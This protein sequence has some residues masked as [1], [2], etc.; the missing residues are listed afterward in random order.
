MPRF[1]RRVG[2]WLLWVAFVLSC[3]FWALLLNGII[4]WLLL[5][6]DNIVLPNGMILRR[7]FDFSRYGRD[8]MFSADGE[9]LLARNIEFICFNDRYVEVVAMHPGYGGLY[10]GETGRPVP[11]DAFYETYS[12]SGLSSRHGCN[13]YY[14]GMVG[15]S[16]MYDSVDSSAHLIPCD[17]RNLDNPALADRSWFDRPCRCSP[18]PECE[19]TRP[20]TR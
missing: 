20:P 17:W 15:P 16:L 19:E 7:E 8:D 10:D 1:L 9:T 18:W 11:G 5:F 4:Q 12:A 2:V 3:V 14:T 6:N 13:G